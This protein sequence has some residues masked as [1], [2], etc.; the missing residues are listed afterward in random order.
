M[1][2]S[3]ELAS[4]AELQ[5]KSNSFKSRSFKVFQQMQDTKD[6]CDVTLSEGISGHRSALR[7]LP[8]A[9]P[10]VPRALLTP[11]L[12]AT[13]ELQTASRLGPQDVTTVSFPQPPPT[14]A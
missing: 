6:F 5:I 12:P 4:M 2:Y 3:Y 1:N 8:S 14:R 10:Q 13:S 7:L 9:C 11:T